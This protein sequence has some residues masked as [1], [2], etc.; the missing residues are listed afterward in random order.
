MAD[1]KHSAEAEDTR[2][3]D[4]AHFAPGALCK[5]PSVVARTPKGCKA[6]YTITNRIQFIPTTRGR[7]LSYDPW[8]DMV[9]EFLAAN[10]NREFATA[11][12]VFAMGVPYDE[13]T[14]DHGRHLKAVM[15][16]IDKGWKPS[17]NI[18]VFSSTQRLRGWVYQGVGWKPRKLRRRFHE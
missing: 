10:G 4:Y 9:H 12:C 15:A 17:T 8:V 16:Q 2:Y 13:Q 6:Y 7:L 1:A 11:D 3:R 5:L 18:A 14:V